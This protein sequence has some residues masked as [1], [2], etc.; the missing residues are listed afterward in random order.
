VYDRELDASFGHL[1]LHRAQNGG[2]VYDLLFA[3]RT[4][5]SHT[6]AYDLGGAGSLPGGLSAIVVDPVAG[7]SERAKGP[8]EVAVEANG[9]ALRTLAVGTDDFLRSFVGNLKPLVFGLRAL[10]NPFRG[11]VTIR[12]TIPWVDVDEVRLSVH[13]MSGRSVWSRS[14]TRGVRFGGNS[15]VWSACDGEGR[16]VASGMYLVRMAVYAKDKKDA[17]VLQERLVYLK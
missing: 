6:V 11:R 12:F 10:P 5:R 9:S 14:M 15:L 16:P 4:G 1:L 7:R 8:Y 17:R 13:D 3:N 2:F